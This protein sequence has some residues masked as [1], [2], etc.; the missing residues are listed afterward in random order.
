MTDDGL[1]CHNCGRDNPSWAQVCRSCGVPLDTEVATVGPGGRIPTDQRSLAAIAATIGTILLAV[2][3]ALFVSGLDPTDAGIGR[4]PT[5]T[6]APTP[7]EPTPTPAPTPEPEPEETPEPTPEPPPELP[8]QIITGIGRDGAA[9]TDE[10]DTFAPGTTFAHAIDL[11]EEEFG[12][13]QITETI[14]R[15]ENGEETVVVDH[16]PLDVPNASL[17]RVAYGPVSTDNLRGEVGGPGTYII[18]AHRGDEVIAEATFT[19]SG[20]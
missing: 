13:T 15:V 5:P 12:V 6:P 1:Q 8:G 9:I 19:L 11:G 3:L 7:E 20:G 4:E 14:S 2:L 10:T 16:Y 17:S 18:R